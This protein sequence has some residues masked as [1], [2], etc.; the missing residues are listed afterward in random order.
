MIS[1][2]LMILAAFC[3]LISLLNW[4]QKIN[5]QSLGLLFMSLSFAFGG[6]D[7]TR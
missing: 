6:Y 5:F 3:F 2:I 4:T 7:A 1:F